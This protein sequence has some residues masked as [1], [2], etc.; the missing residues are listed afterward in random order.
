MEEAD[1]MWITSPA[2]LIMA[3]AKDITEK[4]VGVNCEIGDIPVSGQSDRR[5]GGADALTGRIRASFGMGEFEA[6]MSGATLQPE[7]DTRDP[8]MNGLDSAR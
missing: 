1:A 3:I 4:T 5:T 8:G 6:L 2:S 7:W